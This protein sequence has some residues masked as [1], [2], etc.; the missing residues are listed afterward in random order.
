MAPVIIPKI[1]SVTGNRITITA[2]IPFSSASQAPIIARVADISTA[3]TISARATFTP[4]IGADGTCPVLFVQRLS[5]GGTPSFRDSAALPQSSCGITTDIVIPVGATDIRLNPVGERI[6]TG[7]VQ[8]IIPNGAD[9]NPVIE[10]SGVTDPPP[11][12]QYRVLER[13][14]PGAP[15]FTQ[16]RLQQGRNGGIFLP[17]GGDELRPRGNIFAA[18]WSRECVVGFAN[19][20]AS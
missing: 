17:A 20:G 18:D 14:Y 9:G 3:V 6:G 15:V 11:P 12:V 5:G 1:T 13:R 10:L 19:C 4:A 16:E 2:G 8:L 7:Q